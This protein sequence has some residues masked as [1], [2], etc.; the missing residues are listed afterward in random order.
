MQKQIDCLNYRQRFFL[1]RTTTL[2]LNLRTNSDI[3]I[4]DKN[5]DLSWE[6]YIVNFQFENIVK[7]S[8]SRLI[9]LIKHNVGQ[10][11]NK[12][13][14]MIFSLFIIRK[15]RQTNVNGTRIQFW[16][17]LESLNKSTINTKVRSSNERIFTLFSHQHVQRIF[18]FVLTER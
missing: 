17:T 13:S 8:C 16:L 1:V 11:K 4:P 12:L 9:L 10:T 18:M 5:Y 15:I 7:F 2:G 14:F 3:L 6:K